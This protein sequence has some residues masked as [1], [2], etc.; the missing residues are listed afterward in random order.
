[1]QKEKEVMLVMWNH[2]I[3]NEG[4]AIEK[5]IAKKTNYYRN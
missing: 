5:V 4:A 1:M 3:D 2:F